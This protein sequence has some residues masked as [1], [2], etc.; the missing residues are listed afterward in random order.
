MPPDPRPLRVALVATPDTQVGPLSGLFETLNAFPL[1][2]SFEA[3]LPERPFDVEVVAPGPEPVRAASGLSIGMHRAHDEVPRVDIAI[4]PLMLV[5]GPDW[6]P[7]RYPGLVAWLRRQHRQGALMASACTGVLLLAE[8]GLLAS[9]E[10]TIHW[11]F[12]PTFHRNFPDVR[13]RTEQ[14]L[15]TSGERQEFVMTGGVMSWHD[16]ALHLIAR[17][18]GP[19]AAHVAGRMLMLEWHGDGQTP[20]MEFVPRL[21]H[22]DAR[23]AECQRWLEANAALPAPVERMVRSAGMPRRTLERRFRSATGHA[24]VAYVQQLRVAEARRRLERSDEP[25][26]RIALAVG[27]ENTSYFRRLFK[28]LTGLPPGAYRRRF[29]MRDL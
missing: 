24:P 29:G 25:V 17:Y 12:A 27:Y 8:T 16:L 18:V 26:E 15:I 22:G 21:D 19:T 13:L 6:V 9:R 7:G 3:G 10:A 2:A 23:V 28:R 1:L 5:E 20:Y 4:V 11:A 14:V